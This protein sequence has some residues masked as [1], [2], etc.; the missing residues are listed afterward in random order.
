MT[1]DEKR[2]VARRLILE[3]NYDY[4]YSLV[5]EDEALQDEDEQTLGEIFDMMNEANVEVSW[6]RY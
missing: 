6:G 5:Y 2:G 1:N 4:E 3:W